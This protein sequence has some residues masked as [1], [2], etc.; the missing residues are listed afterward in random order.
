[1]IDRFSSKEEP[2]KWNEGMFR[3]GSQSRC[4][5][6]GLSH[7][8]S[9][10]TVGEFAAKSWRAGWIDADMAILADGLSDQMPIHSP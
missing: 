3:D 7:C 8:P 5:G 6:Y 4:D 1:V 10:Q 2:P 9:A